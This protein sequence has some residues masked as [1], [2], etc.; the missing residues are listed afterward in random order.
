M[1]AGDH[2][3]V[4]DAFDA[5]LAASA[6]QVQEAQEAAAALAAQLAECELQ[7]HSTQATAAAAG[8]R[9]GSPVLAADALAVAAA[10]ESHAARTGSTS[11]RSPSSHASGPLAALRQHQKSIEKQLAKQHAELTKLQRENL[12]LMRFKKQFKSAG[13]KLKEAAAVQAAAESAAQ[14]AG[15]KAAAEAGR[16]ERLQQQVVPASC[17]RALHFHMCVVVA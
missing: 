7:Q 17:L 6:A 11:N 5:A 9:P 3:E 4:F 15:L 10:V 2:A 8:N 13:Q 12:K 14:Q 1:Q 16:A